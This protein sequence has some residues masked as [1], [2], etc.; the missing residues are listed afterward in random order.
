MQQQAERSSAPVGISWYSDMTFGQIDVLQLQAEQTSP[1]SADR[2]DQR[3]MITTSTGSAP[4]PMASVP[5]G[6]G[7]GLLSGRLMVDHAIAHGFYS[8]GL[9]E[10][11]VGNGRPT[12]TLVAT[13][14]VSMEQ[15]LAEYA[16][17]N[18]DMQSSHALDMQ[19]LLAEYARYNPT[20]D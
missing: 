16:R 2:A 19:Q 12:T 14:S 5:I 20:V 8:P 7:E 6:L 3:Q 4:T 18:P 17:Y 9:G 1:V 10:G 15:L 13:P 11:W